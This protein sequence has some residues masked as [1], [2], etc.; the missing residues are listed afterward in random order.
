MARKRG[1]IAGFYDRNKGFLKKAVPVGLSF[2]PGVGIPLAAAAGAA[3]GADTEGKG[4]F[5]GFNV[6]G[7][8]KGGLEGAALG[9]GT[10]GARA[11]LTGGGPMAGT[12]P[13]FGGFGGGANAGGSVAETGARQLGMSLK[14]VANANKIAGSGNRIQGLLSG[15][16]ENKDLIGMAGK[17]VMSALP[18]AA[19]DAA[20]MRAETERMAFEDEKAQREAR[21]RALQ[22][23]F[24]PLLG[25][26]QQ[27]R[28]GMSFGPMYRG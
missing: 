20:M 28:Q 21:Q 24:M 8:I 13:K 4:Y 2:I 27:E 25:Q 22:Q 7:A 26:I 12:V 11:L 16:R 17:G 6:G 1:G 18:D 10:Q 14:D 15:F 3:M 19:S 9:A 23:Y 5:S